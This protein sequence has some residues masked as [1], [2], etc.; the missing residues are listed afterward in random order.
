MLETCVGDGH[1][2]SH[3]ILTY[4]TLY[5]ICSYFI[6]SNRAVSYHPLLQMLGTCMSDDLILSHIPLS[7]LILSH[8]IL[9]YPI[10]SYLILLQ[11]LETCVDDGLTKGIGVSSFSIPQILKIMDRCRIRPANNQVDKGLEL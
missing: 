2:L 6:L 9:S 10:L 3:L 8:L 11:M 7:Y 5:L 4:L 1:I